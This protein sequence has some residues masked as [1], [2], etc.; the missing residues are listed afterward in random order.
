MMVVWERVVRGRVAVF[1]MMTVVV[2]YW[3][4]TLTPST[5]YDVN[6]LPHHYES[7]VH[8]SNSTSDVHTGPAHAYKRLFHSNTRHTQ[9]ENPDAN[10]HPSPA[11][12]ENNVTHGNKIPSTSHSIPRGQT[13]RNSHTRY[14]SNNSQNTGAATKVNNNALHKNNSDDSETKA[15]ENSVDAVTVTG[16]SGDN[17]TNITKAKI[18]TKVTGTRSWTN[19]GNN[20]TKTRR[21][22]GEVASIRKTMTRAGA[23]KYKNNNFSSS[24]S[25]SSLG[26][27]VNTSRPIRQLW[28]LDSRCSGVKVRFGVGLRRV[29]LLS[30]PRSGNTWTRYL[31]EAATGFF[32]SA[33]YNDKTLISL[34]FL[35]E[36]EDHLAGTTILQKTHSENHIT[37]DTDP[38]ILLVRNPLRSLVSLWSWRVLDGTPSQ[39]N[40]SAPLEAYRGTDFHTFTWYHSSLWSETVTSALARFPTLLILYYEHLQQDPIREVRRVLDFLHLPPDEERLTCLTRHLQGPFLGAKKVDDPFTQFEKKIIQTAIKSASRALQEKGRPPLPDYFKT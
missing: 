15:S 26:V 27:M 3:C 20:I 12:V 6:T 4:H 14:N 34:G 18:K 9:V 32:T 39:Y 21:K 16:D 10:P 8:A 11:Q 35:G 1:M 29:W 22:T 24:V 37:Q 7:P 23:L 33:V 19:D 25:T 38:V 30:F 2:L 36:A 40:G 31:M 13:L 17:K 5:T 28:P